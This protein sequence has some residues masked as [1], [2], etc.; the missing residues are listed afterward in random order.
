M[1][2]PR[3]WYVNVFVRDFPAAVE[4]YKE[5][6]GLDLAFRDEEFGYA[7]FATEGAGFALS[8]VDPAQEDVDRLVSRHTGI[9]IGVPDIHAAY[10]E[11]KGRG[12][13]FPMPPTDQP[14]G[15]VLALFS[16][17]EGNVLYLDQLRDH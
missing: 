17:P 1:K 15:G 12:V 6:V 9:A 10:E 14:W 4:F 7:S 3:V 11:M 8:R 2:H 5:K 13:E 16:D